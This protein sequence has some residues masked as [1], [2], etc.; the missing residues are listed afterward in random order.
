MGRKNKKSKPS[1]GQAETPESSTDGK[2]EMS[3][4]LKSD[5]MNLVNQVIDKC[6]TPF[7]TSGVQEWK[8]FLDVNNLVEQIRTKQRGFALHKPAKER[9]EVFGP[10]ISWLN[11]NLVD[12]SS[13]AIDEYQEEG[14]GLKTTRQ[15]VN[16][17]KFLEVPRSVMLTSETAA[18]SGLAPLITEDRILQAMPNVVLS[19]HLLCE[20]V[21]PASFFAPYIAI[22][23]DSYS[24]ALYYSQ[25]ELQLLKGSPVLSDVLGQRRN[26]ARQ[27]AYFYRLFQISEDAAN[28][29]IKDFCYDDYRWAVSSVMTR[30]NQVPS[31]E[32]TENRSLALIPLWDMCN[33][34]EGQI[35]TDYDPQL[36]KSECYAIKPFAVGEQIF[37][38]YGKR[39]NAEL[40]LHNG[41]VFTD[42][43]NDNM[44][45][46]LGI[47]KNDLLQK[48]KADL[49]SKLNIIPHR[50]VLY[51]GEEPVDS[52][53]LAFL[54]IFNMTEEELDQFN[55]GKSSERMLLRDYGERVSPAN[56]V[57]VWEFLETRIVLLL[58]GYPNTIIE[59][60]ELLKPDS[61]LMI[62]G[63]YGE[64]ARHAVQ[65][66]KME[67]HILQ[68]TY[69]LAIKQ[70]EA[71]IKKKTRDDNPVLPTDDMETE[72]SKLELV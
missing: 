64:R 59:D 51:A 2:K 6:T 49:I 68:K 44:K 26:I 27:Y 62:A 43:K 60:E 30:Q 54:R 65:L 63:S 47:S 57:K 33:H 28:L 42:N 18:E 31:I 22:L 9:E 37:I 4:Q 25:D 15:L 66:R 38:Y 12:T 34:C 45:F 39:S 3:K 20:A 16:D 10:F 32:S 69:Q 52:D 21:N 72:I 70:K 71:A 11:E 46:K 50:L 58:R 1:A 35:T 61:L 53:V 48:K 55:E 14:Y 67:K 17:E 40:L 5:L 19:L 24:T 56:E 23:P 36:N 41:F 8:E 13:V 7:S 29:P